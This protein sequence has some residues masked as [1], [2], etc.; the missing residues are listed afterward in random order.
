MILASIGFAA[1]LLAASLFYLSLRAQ[2]RSSTPDHARASPMRRLIEQHHE[3][4]I[5]NKGGNF[6]QHA[7]VSGVIECATPLIAPESRT[8]CVAYDYRVICE[9]EPGAAGAAKLPA[10]TPDDTPPAEEDAATA[11]ACSHSETVR[12]ESEHVRFYVRDG[13][14]RVL[15]DPQGAHLER[16]VTVERSEPH[17]GEWS[18]AEGRRIIGYRYREHVLAVG[19]S[20]QVSGLARSHDGQVLL[21]SDPDRPEQPLTIRYSQA[22]AP[23]PTPAARSPHVALLASVIAFAFGV[24]SL[25]GAALFTPAAGFD[26]S[27]VTS[28]FHAAATSVAATPTLSA[29]TT[30]SDTAPG[31]AEV[32]PTIPLAFQSKRDGNW[33]IYVQRADGSG[34]LRLTNHLADDAEPDWSPD[35]TRIVFRS[36]R[37]GNNDIYVINADGSGLQRLTDHP[38]WDGDPSWLPTGTHIAFHTNRDGSDSIYVMQ[39]DGSNQ[40]P[41]ISSGGLDMAPAWQSVAPAAHAHAAA[42]VDH[43]ATQVVVREGNFRSEPR[44]DETT[45]TGLVCPGDE[46]M[47]LEAHREQD[48]EVPWLRVR[49]T[50]LGD[51]CNP[52]RVARESEGWMSEILLTESLEE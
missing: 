45:R 7:T 43:A 36:N 23:A 31:V 25:T 39:A 21:T 41:L 29:T 18:E 13:S 10:T 1:L 11:P 28:A 2:R 22:T 47:I 8:P 40:Q 19:R 26:S 42:P 16:T 51:A 12:H 52:Q 9:H 37:A 49:V 33:E 46:V 44:L 5:S 50:A 27:R 20:V 35:G 38:E 4:L 32:A 17:E 15:V 30:L 6:R 14:R 48:P 34:L 3:A 24:V